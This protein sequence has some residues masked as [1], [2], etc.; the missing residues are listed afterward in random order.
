MTRSHEC[1]PDAIVGTTESSGGTLAADLFGAGGAGGRGADC[2]AAVGAADDGAT[3]SVQ[4]PPWQPQFGQTHSTVHFLT[5]TSLSQ[6][7]FTSLRT[8]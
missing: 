5:G 6:G 1:N 2:G 4:L 3:L 7:I 8:S